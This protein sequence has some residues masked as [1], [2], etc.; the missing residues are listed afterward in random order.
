MFNVPARVTAP[1]VA[2]DGVN[3]VVPALNDVTATPDM[4]VQAGNPVT[5]D[6]IWPDVPMPSMAVVPDADWY[7]TEPAA[8]PARFVAVV[9][10]VADPAVVA[11]VA[12]AA[13]P[14]MDK[15]LA[16]PVK[17]VPGPLN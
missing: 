17:P 16:V 14:P 11:L 5:T 7:G 4:E 3:P 10:V 6:K 8:P 2:E 13:L 12:V 15:P 1:L 9:A